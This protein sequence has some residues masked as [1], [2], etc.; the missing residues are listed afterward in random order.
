MSEATMGLTQFLCEARK[1][2]DLS[3]SQLEKLCGISQKSLNTYEM[4]QTCPS[5]EKL[6]KICDALEIDYQI[7]LELLRKKLS[8]R[9]KIGSSWSEK[10]SKQLL[11]S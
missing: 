5:A 6:R 4:G 8:F 11:N 10:R 7:G 9:S 1:E 2:K 3:Y